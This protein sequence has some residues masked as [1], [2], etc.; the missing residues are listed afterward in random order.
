MIGLVFTVL[1]ILIL[2][3]IGGGIVVWA[4]AARAPEGFE[5]ELGY[6]SNP[7]QPALNR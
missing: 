4:V 7:E 3:I 2:V 5:D 6:Q 1:L